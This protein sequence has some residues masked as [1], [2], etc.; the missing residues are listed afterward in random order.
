M[1]TRNLSVTGTVPAPRTAAATIA[2]SSRGF[3][4]IAEPPPLLVT[5]RT[6]QPKFMS[7]WSTRPSPTSSFTAS[8]TW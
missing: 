7:M 6:G 3:S 4:G 5:F 1:P 2:R 8:P